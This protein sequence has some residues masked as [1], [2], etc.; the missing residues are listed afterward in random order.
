[1]RLELGKPPRQL[2]ARS[3]VRSANTKA[4]TADDVVAAA[5]ETAG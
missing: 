3:N 2:D 1:M 5:G 4:D